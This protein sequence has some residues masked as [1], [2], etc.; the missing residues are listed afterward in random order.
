MGTGRRRGAKPFLSQAAVGLR[1]FP[2]RELRAYAVAPSWQRG[3]KFALSFV[4]PTLR[5]TP[6]YVDTGDTWALLG[7]F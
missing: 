6:A 7:S 2:G 3:F 5:C 1:R 4:N